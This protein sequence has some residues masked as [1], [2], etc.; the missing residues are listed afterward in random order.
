MIRRIFS[1]LH[2]KIVI[3]GVLIL[4][5]LVVFLEIV[6]QLSEYFVWIYF[7]LIALSFCMSVYIINKNDNPT[8]KIAWVLLIMG[9]PVFGGLIYLLFGGQKVPKELRKRDTEAISIYQ[10]IAWQNAEI[11]AE[12][13]KE[14]LIAHKQAN[15]LWKNAIF[16]IYNHTE[17]TF[18][19][20]GEDKFDAM[21]EELKKAEKFIF[22]EYFIIAPGYMWD[23]ILDVLVEKVKQGVE[24]RVMYDDFGCI[25]YLPTDYY[26]ILLNLGI[27]AKVFNPIKPRLAIQMNNRDHRKILVVDGKVAMTGG[28]NLA[29]EYINR[30]KRFGHWKDCS[31]MIKGEAVWNFTL[32]FL[33]FWNY[34]EKEKDDVYTYK[35]DVKEFVDIQNDG[36][37]QPYSDSPTDEENVGEY[38]HINM[39]NGASK[40]V[41]AS[42]PY[43]VID[44]EMKTALLLAA[45]NGIDV[46]ILV[47]HIPDKWYVFELTRSNY[48]DLIEGG[49]RIYEY[50]PGF[51]HSKTFV[52]D[53]EMA[54]VGTVNM[55]YRSYYLHYECG[56][57]FYK[58]KVVMDVKKDYM[59]TL[60]KSHLVT[61]EECCNVSLRVKIMRAV[62]N[63]FSPMM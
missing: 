53:D 63:L 49:V 58:S 21:I 3:I 50:T 32:M 29:D 16:P 25:T 36:Y 44:N 10:E 54:I 42:T 5:Q 1:L 12:L 57:W 45:K 23:T 26:K 35:A 39:I 24:V 38:T 19:P 51:V 34:D 40:Y 8:Y 14:N 48:K 43:L 11:M 22:M 31:V 37:V 9:L 33:Q 17:T 46:R 41:Y 55:D 61:M 30:K 6:F 15:Y 60:E 7:I 59:E 56:V 18:F 27:K 28:V 62:L 20:L 47:P 2:N 13:E 52:V 4:I